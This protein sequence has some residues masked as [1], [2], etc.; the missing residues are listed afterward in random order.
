[1]TSQRTRRTRRVLSGRLV[2][3]LCVGAFVLLWGS[4]GMRVGD[5]RSRCLMDA[6]AGQTGSAELTGYDIRLW[7]RAAECR[8]R[9]TDGVEASKRMELFR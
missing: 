3:L 4:V 6:P 8:W 5:L 1:M 9:G 2:G 7:D